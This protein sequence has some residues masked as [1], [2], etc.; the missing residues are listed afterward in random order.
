MNLIIF[1]PPGSGK[2]TYANRLKSQLGV[3]TIAMG[4]ILRELAKEETGLAKEINV[5]LRQGKLVSDKIAIDVLKNQLEKQA[6]EGVILDGYPRTLVQAKALEDLVTIDAIIHLVVPDWI[7][8]ERLSS[9]RIC[10]KCGEVYNIR[11]LKPRQPE[12]CDKCGGKLL[13]R[14]DDTTEVIK[15]RIEIY[16]K[17]TRPLLQY[18]RKRIPIVLAKCDR[19]DT[20]P[21]VV[22]ASILK[23]LE[24]LDLA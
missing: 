22:V 17:Q 14:A 6:V 7:I 19:V 20:P 16:E 21:E 13:Q 15:E 3:A 2:G 11:F 9:R 18:F 12:T 23:G 5:F 8:I 1:G 4:D 24:A 10:S